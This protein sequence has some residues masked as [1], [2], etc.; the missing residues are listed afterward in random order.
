VRSHAFICM[1]STIS[2]STS[3]AA[4]PFDL[5]RHRAADTRRPG[6]PRFGLQGSKKKAAAKKNAEG[7][8][9]AAFVNCSSTSGL[10]PATACV[11]PPHPRSSSI[12]RDADADSATVFEL[13]GVPSKAP[14]VARTIWSAA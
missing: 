13:L 8:M 2:A 6:R 5:H 9:C 11:L 7:E 1:L 12:R 14:R 10:L 3:A 4:S